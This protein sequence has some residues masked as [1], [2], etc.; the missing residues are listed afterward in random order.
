MKACICHVFCKDVK[1]SN[2][3]V[4]EFMNEVLVEFNMF[5]KAKKDGKT[6]TAFE[7]KR[8]SDVIVVSFNF[9]LRVY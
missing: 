3:V 1:C 8:I 9:L 6:K 2:A 7:K 4:S 5:G